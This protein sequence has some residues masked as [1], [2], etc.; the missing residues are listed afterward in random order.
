[1]NESIDIEQVQTIK[2]GGAKGVRIHTRVYRDVAHFIFQH[3]SR[4]HE[5]TIIDLLSRIENHFQG[6]SKENGDF[7]FIALHVKLDLEGRGYLKLINSKTNP[8]QIQ[9]CICIT[10]R[11]LRYFKSVLHELTGHRLR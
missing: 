10:K 1:V 5:V 7:M 11:G 2:P 8:N 6:R 9:K 4:N 3:L